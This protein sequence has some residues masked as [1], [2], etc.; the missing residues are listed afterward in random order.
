MTDRI[1]RRTANWTSLYLGLER[2][3]TVFEEAGNRP[4]APPPAPTGTV[5]LIDRL[6]ASVNL[7]PIDEL[8]VRVGL[9]TT[10][11]VRQQIAD[12]ESGVAFTDEKT[13]EIWREAAIDSARWKLH[14]MLT[15]SISQ[16]I[17]M[18][19]LHARVHGHVIVEMCRRVGGCPATGSPEAYI[20]TS[21]TA[22][23][24]GAEAEIQELEKTVSLLEKQQPGYALLAARGMS[25]PDGDGAGTPT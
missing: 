22:A 21:E 19:R 13:K 15:N 5:S 1:I 23:I 11:Q 17:G 9:D 14:Y 4:P 12:C 16:R 3:V 20:I 6:R 24:A 7:G 10:D 2:H 8:R 18:L 25:D